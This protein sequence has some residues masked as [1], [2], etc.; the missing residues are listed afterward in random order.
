MRIYDTERLILRQIDESF[1]NKTLT[2]YQK[3]KDFLLEW[4]AQRS[5]NFYTLEGQKKILAKD[6]ELYNKG[7]AFKLWLFK[8]EG[9]NSLSIIGC[10]SFSLI[11]RGILQ[12]CVLGYKLDR[13]EL[14]KG[15]ITEALR[16]GIEIMF[17]D[18]GLNR[19]DSPIMPKNKAS[20]QVVKKLGFEYEGLSRKMIKVNGVWEDHMRWSKVN[21]NSNNSF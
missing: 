14:N 19:I 17:Q 6:T 13:D 9:Q 16:K 8:K 12:S 4:E 10:I 7:E 3:N 15:F 1:A 20:V 5:P 11:I 18:F 2:Y 21:E